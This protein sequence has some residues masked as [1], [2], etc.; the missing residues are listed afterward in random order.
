MSKIMSA[1]DHFSPFTRENLN[2]HFKKLFD[3]WGSFLNSKDSRD[4]VH[5]QYAGWLSPKAK[6]GM[7]EMFPG[8]STF[9]EVFVCNPGEEYYGY[10]SYEDI[11]TRRFR[12]VR[13]DR[14]TGELHNHIIGNPREAAFCAY[15]ENVQET[16]QFFIEGESYRWHSP[17]NGTIKE[18]VDVPRMY[19]PQSPSFRLAQQFQISNT[20]S[21]QLIFLEANDHDIGLMCSSPS[22]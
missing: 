6:D 1:Q 16:D 9:E 21:R 2:R 12:N 11:F 19:F 5:D 20:A 3:T 13:V 10:T 7:M 17:V 4:V 14:P 8:R 22:E 18:I 15:R